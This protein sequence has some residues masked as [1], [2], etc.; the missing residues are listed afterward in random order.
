MLEI[1]QAMGTGCSPKGPS[2]GSQHPRRGSQ[3]SATPASENLTPS[4]GICEYCR[5]AVQTFI[6]VNTSIHT[7][8]RM[9][10]FIVTV[11]TIVR[12]TNSPDDFKQVNYTNYNTPVSSNSSQ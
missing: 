5:P 3:P 2:F 10:T 1:G 12:P 7:H 9:Q 4:L 8:T 11:L 6:Q